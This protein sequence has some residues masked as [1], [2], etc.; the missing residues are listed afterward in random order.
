M[1]WFLISASW[2]FQGQISLPQKFKN[3]SFE[4]TKLILHG[5]SNG[6]P[7]KT[8]P[9]SN[10]KFEFINIG[11]GS[12]F[13][14]VAHPTLAFDPIQVDVVT[15]KNSN[16]KITAHLV[17]AQ[18]RK[19]PKL[20]YPLGLAPSD[21][22]IFFEARETFSVFSLLANPMVLLMA[23]SGLIMVVM[24]KMQP[25]LSPDE[26]SALKQDDG[27]ASS[28]L[29]SSCDERLEDKSATSGTNPKPKKRR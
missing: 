3:F 24:P 18:H 1:I 17:D 20:K 5:G 28:F 7:I 2:G 16:T 6:E 4:S 19:G 22:S 29:R 10:G 14:Q 13:L 25:E 11:E 15:D 23:F 8:S 26:A 12:Y 9:L 27:I 21:V